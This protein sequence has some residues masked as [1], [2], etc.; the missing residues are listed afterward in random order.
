MRTVKNIKK[1]IV[2]A[3]AIFVAL[4]SRL[5]FADD[6]IIPTVDTGQQGKSWMYTFNYYMA[7]YAAPIVLYGGSIFLLA[8][9]CWGM[10]GGY[11]K[12]QQSQD[13]GEFKNSL[14]GGVLMITI[15]VI[16]FAFGGQILTKWQASIS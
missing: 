2:A 7:N 16:L 11:K 9:S 5:S 14:V 10:Y 12:Y 6:S 1:S 4:L 8:S 13:F 3:I 15:A